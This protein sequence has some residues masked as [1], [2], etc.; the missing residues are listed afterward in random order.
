MPGVSEE[1]TRP[2]GGVGDEGS[3][4]VQSS[5]DSTEGKKGKWVESF[6]HLPY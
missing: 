5:P 4:S 6:M 1:R 3:D 2:V